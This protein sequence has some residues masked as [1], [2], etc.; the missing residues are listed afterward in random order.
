ML[1]T[2]SQLKRYANR[3]ERL[4]VLDEKDIR[5]VQQALLEMMDDFHALCERNGLCYFLTG[6]TALGAVRNQ[7]FIPW[8]DDI[9]LIMP[10]RDYDRLRECVDR[11]LSDRYWI[12]SLETSEACDLPFSKFRK[13]G[14]KYV[15]IF[16]NEPERAGL[17]ID[18]FPLEDM[19]SSGIVRILNGV[20]DEALFLIASCVRMYN[21]KERL[22]SYVEGSPLEKTVR[23]KAAIGKIFSDRK[24]RNIWF[25]RCENWQSKCRNPESKYVTVSCGRG[26]YFGETYLRSEIFPVQPVSFEGRTYWA[27]KNPDHLLTVL[28]GSGYMTP[29]DPSHRE[30]H[31]LVELDLGFRKEER[32]YDQSDE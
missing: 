2:F 10:R 15:E 31:S 5:D 19:Y 9:D 1:K 28:Y 32:E 29:E 21:K 16:E 22:L 20:A 14:T 3:N 11:E 6:G 23:L 7:G 26:H 13:K 12:Q 27:A 17:F 25:R 30:V 4:R 24:D 8:D 18:V